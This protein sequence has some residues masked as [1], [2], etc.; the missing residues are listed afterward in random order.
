VVAAPIDMDSIKESAIF[1]MVSILPVS[2][3]VKSE[4]YL[5]VSSIFPRDCTAGGFAAQRLYFFGSPRGLG[6]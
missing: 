3:D 2:F 5:S 6:Q 4:L 1:R